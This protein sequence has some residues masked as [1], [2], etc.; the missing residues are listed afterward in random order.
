MTRGW[1]RRIDSM[2][3]VQRLGAMTRGND[4]DAPIRPVGGG[5]NCSREKQVHFNF[6]VDPNRRQAAMRTADVPP[7]LIGMAN[8]RVSEAMT[9]HANRLVR[10]ITIGLRKFIV[11]VFPDLLTTHKM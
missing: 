2:L 1:V 4:S 9:W 7:K 3:N 5:G 11:N 10:L 6:H 8:G